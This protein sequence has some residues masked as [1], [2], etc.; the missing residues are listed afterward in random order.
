MK[1]VIRVIALPGVF[2][3]EKLRAVKKA[4]SHSECF[5]NALPLI[6]SREIYEGGKTG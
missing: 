2:S 1:V 5:A 4:I 6:F 3:R